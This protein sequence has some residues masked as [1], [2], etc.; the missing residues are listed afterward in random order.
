MPN[1]QPP[2]TLTPLIEDKVAQICKCLEPFSSDKK[3][4]LS[5]I[6]CRNNQVRSVQASL[7]I[8]NNTL[9]LKQVQS[10]AD[11]KPI[12]GAPRE[13]QEVKN[14]L[15][16][17]EAMEAWEPTSQQDLCEAHSVLM[18]GLVERAGQFREEGVGIYRGETLIHMAPPANRVPLLMQDLLDW[19]ASSD[20]HP[21]IKS[22]IFHY[23]FEFI[24]PFVDGNG[25]MGRLWQ[26]LILSR[27]QS[28]FAYLP[29]E[30]VVYAEQLNYYKALSIS[31]KASEATA[32][33]EFMLQALRVAIE[34]NRDSLS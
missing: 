23:E 27:W 34:E 11:G 9:S 22:C 32:F 7:A 24:H 5:P 25:R 20:L 33:V 10:I 13:V 31:D 18:A 26:T 3:D 16:A 8:E 4:K 28:L 15:K 14:A 2:F 29:V 1:Y 12:I 21:L 17:Y 6:L 19:L 30:T